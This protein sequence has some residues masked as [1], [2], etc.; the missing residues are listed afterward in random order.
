MNREFEFKAWVLYNNEYRLADSVTIHSDGSWG[1]EI[2][3]EDKI[4]GCPGKNSDFILQYIGLKDINKKKI[5]EHD[6]L[7]D[8]LNNI[9]KVIYSDKY[10]G[11]VAWSVTDTGNHD[12]CYIGNILNEGKI[13]MK[14]LKK[15]GNIHQNPELLKVS[16]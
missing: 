3:I 8:R 13:I 7:K 5:Y 11:F 2:E 4:I 16:S 1:Y 15:I 9:W 10:A 12:E 14:R 6:L